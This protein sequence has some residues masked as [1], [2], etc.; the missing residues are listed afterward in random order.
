MTLHICSFK[1]T[2]CNQE[3]KIPVVK[4]AKVAS[5]LQFL[6]LTLPGPVIVLLLRADCCLV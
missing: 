5:K 4:T 1:D 6:I 3:V 2:D